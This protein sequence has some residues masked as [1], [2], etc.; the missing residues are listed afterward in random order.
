MTQNKINSKWPS[1]TETDLDAVEQKIKRKLPRSLREFY[2]KTNGG[3]P[4]KDIFINEDD[5][6]GV[7]EILPVIYGGPGT[8][9]EET[10]EDLVTSRALIPADLIPFAVNGGGDYYCINDEGRVFFVAMDPPDDPPVLVADSIDEFIN[11][12]V[13]HEDLGWV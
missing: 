8:N 11:G 4:E 9:F 13:S 3:R 5:E 7:Q 12:M 1:V 6:Y 2:L 10:Y